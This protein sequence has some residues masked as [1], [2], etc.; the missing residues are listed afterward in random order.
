M[1]RINKIILLQIRWLALRYN[2]LKL[3]YWADRK[4]FELRTVF[5]M[6]EFYYRLL[7]WLSM[8]LVQVN[9]FKLFADKAIHTIPY[10]ARFKMAEPNN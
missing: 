4:I 5:V 3:Y 6:P 10:H 1:K 9:G 7:F 8:R 2:Q